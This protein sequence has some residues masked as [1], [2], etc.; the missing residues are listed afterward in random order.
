MIQEIQSQLEELK[1]TINQKT[2]DLVNKNDALYKKKRS[3]S[4]KV[5]NKNV[6]KALNL[7]H[8][9]LKNDHEAG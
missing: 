7:K 6:P 1:I 4:T 8:G 5:V 2:M 3:K 9:L